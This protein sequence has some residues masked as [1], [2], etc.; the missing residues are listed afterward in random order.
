MSKTPAYNTM[1]GIENVELAGISVRA[2]G[3]YAIQK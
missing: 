1:A 2:I 3:A